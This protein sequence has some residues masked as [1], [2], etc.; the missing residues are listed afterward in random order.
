MKKFNVRDELQHLGGDE[1]KQFFSTMSGEHTV[2]TLNL[3]GDINISMI[4][5]LC[6]LFGIKKMHILGKR[7]Y[8]SLANVG[9]HNY[10][11]VVRTTCTTGDHSERL[12]I[13]KISAFLYEKSKS[14]QIVFIEQHPCRAIMLQDMVH[15]LEATGCSKPLMFVLG[16]EGEGI[17][18]EL[19][20]L[21]P[22]A[23][24]VEIPQLGIC[25]S[26]NVA[27]AFSIV[28]WELHRNTF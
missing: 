13:F 25:R 1:I 4:V 26:F 19:I 16:C 3:K 17:P 18:T 6:S 11:E 14:Y 5:R 21:F 7:Y 15:T 10:V 8:N 22:S 24:I 27:T 9:M 12:D 23:H 20:E 2:V 28:M